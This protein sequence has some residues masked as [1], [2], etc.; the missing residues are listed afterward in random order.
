MHKRLDN[1]LEKYRFI[2][3]LQYGFRTSHST[4]HCLLD[5]TENIRKALDDN[6]YAAG[7]FVDQKAFDTVDHDI[8]LA[9]LN[10]FGIRGKCNLWFRSYLKGRK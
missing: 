10:H 6:K 3:D 1:F 5:L 9:K 7:V 4:N 2:Y 8:L